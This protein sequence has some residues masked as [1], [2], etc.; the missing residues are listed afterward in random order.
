MAARSWRYTG[1][2]A[3]MIFMM[4]SGFVITGLLLTRKEAWLPFITRR[5][6]RLFPA[7]WIA[8]VQDLLSP[9][10]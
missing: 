8:L 1:S 3:V 10:P 5:A 4:L 9:S 7:Y 6:F 2:G